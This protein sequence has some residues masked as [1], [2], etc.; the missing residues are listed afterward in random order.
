MSE[1]AN[2]SVEDTSSEAVAQATESIEHNDVSEGSSES[3]QRKR[4]DA[5]YNWAE[6]RRKMQEKDQQIE[7]LQNQFSQISKRAPTP[8]EED[9][10]AQLAEDDILTVAQAKKLAQRMA[11][12]V[13]EDVIK[14]RDAATVDERVQLKYPDYADTVTKEN[15]ELLKKTEPELAKSLYHMPDPY[16]QAV[17][18]YKLLKRVAKREDGPSLEKKKAQENSQKPL[19]VNAVTK[20][21]AIG[22]AHIFENGLTKELKAQLWKEMQEAKKGA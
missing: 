6:M 3:E 5:E 8:E 20:Q 22:N 12:N 10:L 16:E 4:N 13:A 11:R 7:D 2:M 14:Q 19:S 15:I 1:E 9:E 21:S 18:A 17:A